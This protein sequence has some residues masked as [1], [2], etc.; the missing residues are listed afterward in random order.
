[1]ALNVTIWNEYTVTKNNFPS[2]NKTPYKLDLILTW[3]ENTKC[4]QC[5]KQKQKK[6]SVRITVTNQNT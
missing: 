5:Q 6:S 4:C 2:K 1:M 3:N